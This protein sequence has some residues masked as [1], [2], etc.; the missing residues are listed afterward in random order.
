LGVFA[1]VLLDAYAHSARAGGLDGR[2][3]GSVTVMQRAGGALNANLHF[4]TLVVDGVFTEGDTGA[5]EFHPA[6]VP[7]D[8][9]SRR[10]PLRSRGPSTRGPRAS[11]SGVGVKAAGRSG[12]T[13]Y[14]SGRGVVAVLG[15]RIG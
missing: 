1:R 13:D 11:R 2:R 8:T 7:S 3:T 15:G 6:P 9:G 14:G 5:L 12:A 4:H 10:H